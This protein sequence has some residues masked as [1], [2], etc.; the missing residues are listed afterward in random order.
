VTDTKTTPVIGKQMIKNQTKTIKMRCV[1]NGATHSILL[2]G[3]TTDNYTVFIMDLL[4][5]VHYT[6]KISPSNGG[7]AQLSI[8]QDMATGVYY[9][10]V[11]GTR[12]D[13]SRFLMR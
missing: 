11:K 13:I 10:V 3:L 5:K 4:G 9:G 12:G 1:K 7:I 6:K 8:G 2:N